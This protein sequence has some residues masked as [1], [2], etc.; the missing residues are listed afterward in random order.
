MLL[1]TQLE[2]STERGIM[3]KWLVVIDD[4]MLVAAIAAPIETNCFPLGSAFITGF[5]LAYRYRLRLSGCCWLPPHSS[6]LV[7]RM[8]DGE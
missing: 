8:L 2:H 5:P 4:K 1:Q 3:R 7:N 6:P